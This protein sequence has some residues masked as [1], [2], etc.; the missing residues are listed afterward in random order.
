MW[1][2]HRKLIVAQFAGLA[3]VVAFMLA[4]MRYRQTGV[5]QEQVLGSFLL[6]GIILFAVEVRSLLGWLRERHAQ[7]TGN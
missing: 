2:K 3:A 5:F 7:K 1:Q 6:F 4:F